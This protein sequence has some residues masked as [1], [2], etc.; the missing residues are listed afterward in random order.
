MLH[1]GQHA[2]P[3]AWS[4]MQCCRVWWADLQYVVSTW[5]MEARLQALRR[6][7]AEYCMLGSQLVLWSCSISITDSPRLCVLRVSR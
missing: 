4:L 5:L 2:A 1:L 3:S 6:R 7:L